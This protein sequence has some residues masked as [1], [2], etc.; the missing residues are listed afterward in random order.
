[1][2]TKGSPMPV[3]R[4]VRPEDWRA[5]REL[6]LRAL[7]TDPLAF[8]STLARE[9]AY[10]DRTWEERTA[11]GAAGKLSSTWVAELPGGPLVGMSAGARVEGTLHVFAMWVDPVWRGRGL[12]AQLLD[13]VIVW[14][15]EVAPGEELELQVN[16]RQV[17]AV[18]LYE[19]KGFR[20]TGHREPL[21]HTEGEVVESMVLPASVLP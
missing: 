6:R 11:R 17:E 9:E 2:T 4:R 13:R 10:D 21:G 14:V 12:G 19:R 15:R 5:Q 18:R 7:R 1:M 3:V 8:G 20:R 16:P